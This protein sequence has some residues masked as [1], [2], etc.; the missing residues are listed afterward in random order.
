MNE[1]ETERERERA[2]KDKRALARTYAGMLSHGL[3]HTLSV[4][5]SQELAGLQNSGMLSICVSIRVVRSCQGSGG[6]V[7][8]GRGGDHFI[9]PLAQAKKR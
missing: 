3:P 6:G 5:Q 1:R 2:S 4:L 7:E 9:L 8:G